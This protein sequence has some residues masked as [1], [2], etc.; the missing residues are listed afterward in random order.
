MN[1]NIAV[2]RANIQEKQVNL[3]LNEPK[4]GKLSHKNSRPISAENKLIL[5]E[6]PSSSIVKMKESEVRQA[7][8]MADPI[9]KTDVKMANQ[10]LTLNLVNVFHHQDT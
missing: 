9:V 8:Q 10:D 2:K 3:P 5:I 1:P 6:S 7:E 4:Q